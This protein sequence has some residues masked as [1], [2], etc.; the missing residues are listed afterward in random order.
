MDKVE[1]IVID[2]SMKYG[3]DVTE[4]LEHISV[5]FFQNKFSDIFKDFSKENIIE[6]LK[7][8]AGCDRKK[9]IFSTMKDW[10]NYDFVKFIEQNNISVEQMKNL[11]TQSVESIKAI[12]NEKIK[13]K[14]KRNIQLLKFI[15]E[16]QVGDI[17]DRYIIVEK[18][19]GFCKCI[20]LEF[21]RF[22][23]KLNEI[24]LHLGC[25]F[26]NL[27]YIKTKSY[28]YLRNKDP[29]IA[30]QS[31][32]HITIC[33][34]VENIHGYKKSF[35]VGKLDDNEKRNSNLL[36][37]TFSNIKY[38]L[39]EDYPEDFNELPKFLLNKENEVITWCNILELEYKY[40][41]DVDMIKKQYK[42]KALL[43]HPDRNTEEDTTLLFQE[44]NNAYS[45]L[46]NLNP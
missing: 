38:P 29:Y 36:Y 32:Y 12:K 43:L 37:T 25:N 39:P 11:L 40:K 2:L 10:N 20:C 33:V 30:R 35:V 45:N 42:R 8:N 5:K 34:E 18:C 14:E 31:W 23:C 1:D 22:H 41:N 9:H 7:I 4:A 19:D 13:H 28:Q 16:L 27:D 26:N 3:F 44:L 15:E 17:V 46:I 6:A 24:Q 21:F